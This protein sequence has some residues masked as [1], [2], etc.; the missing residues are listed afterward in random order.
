[1]IDHDASNAKLT[2]PALYGKCPCRT[3]GLSSKIDG[4]ESNETWRITKNQFYAV[5]IFV[6]RRLIRA[7]DFLNARS[8]R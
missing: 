3:G 1:V 8:A 6:Y 5:C 2:M 7:M 4:I